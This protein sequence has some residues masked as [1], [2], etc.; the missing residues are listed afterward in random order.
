MTGTDYER[1]YRHAPCGLV[2]TDVTGKVLGVNDTLLEWTGYAEAQLVGANFTAML[3]AGSQIFFETRHTQILHLEGSVKEVALTLRKADGSIL[4][5]LINSTITTTGAGPVVQT[6]VFDATGRLEYENE[7][8]RARRSAESSE[9]RVRVLQEISSLFGVSVSDEDVAQAFADVAKEAFAATETA[10]LLRDVDGLYHLAAGVNPLADSVPPIQSLR[11]TP[12]E[13]IVHATDA[14]SEH[15]VLAAGLRTARLESLS[16]T[17]LL[18]DHER[19]GVLVCFFGR[20]REFDERAFGLQRALG[21]Q[22]SQT[23]VRVR[24]Q[25]RLEHLALHDPLTGLANRQLLQHELEMALDSARTTAQ[26][27]AVLFLDVDEFKSVNDRWGHATGDAVLRELGERLR[28]GVRT[29]DVVGRIGGDEFVAICR[30]ADLDA[31]I[32]IADRILALTRQPIVIEGATIRVSMSAGVSTFDPAEDP[33]ATGSDLLTS[34]DV[35]M[36]RSKDSG[37][38]RVTLSASPGR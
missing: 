19:L 17:P 11:N 5:V 27:V 12:V 16:I 6:A 26:P 36:Y 13:I 33:R 23:L 29:D 9:E 32:S 38:D 30:N 22:A 18:G 8:L 21:R 35:A 25:R 20:R 3:D 34:A 15:P 7:L 31:A 37:K 2:R 28:T 4:P 24:L 14:E 1:L 10:V